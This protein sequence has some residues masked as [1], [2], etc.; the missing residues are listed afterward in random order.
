MSDLEKLILF[1]DVGRRS[2][3]ISGTHL[4][5]EILIHMQRLHTFI[6]DIRSIT[7]NVDAQHLLTIDDIQ[8]TFFD[9]G[10]YPVGGFG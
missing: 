1:L 2:T 9:H 5:N 8:R 7:T 6:F 10:H 3:F 4:H